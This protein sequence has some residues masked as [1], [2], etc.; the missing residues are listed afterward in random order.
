[1]V[2]T[3]LLVSVVT[4]SQ[5]L[6]VQ[7]ALM[8]SYMPAMLLSG[9][10]FPIENMPWWLRAIAAAMPARYFLTTLRGAMLKGNGALVLAPE[11]LALG[12]F[13]AVVVALAVARFRRKLA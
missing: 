5:L 3:G 6:A 13:A 8:V 10:M 11:L 2:G 12:A 4:K 1:M 7:L 9:F